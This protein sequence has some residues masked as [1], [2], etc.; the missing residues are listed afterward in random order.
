MEKNTPFNIFVLAVFIGLIAPLAIQD[1]M[2]MDGQIYAAVSHNLANGYG[3]FWFPTFSKYFMAEYSEQLPLFFWI[4]GAF[5]KVLGSSIYTE[6]IFSFIMAMITA[7]NISLIW[8]L[9]YHDQ[10]QLKV[11]T[12]LPIFYWIMIPVIS[13]SYIHN[14]EE[15]LMSVFATASVYFTL[16]GFITNKNL[17]LNILISGILIFLTSFCK[18]VQGLFPIVTIAFYWLFYKNI[19]FK[20]ALGYSLLLSLVPVI[21]YGFLLWND[22]SYQSIENYFNNRI[23]RTFTKSYSATTDNHFS[24]LKQIFEQLIPVFILLLL[25]FAAFRV[26]LKK[27]L[28]SINWKPFGFFISL[29]LAGSLPLMVTLEQRGFYLTTSLPFT[30]LALAGI[31]AAYLNPVLS[32]L[33]KNSKGLRNFKI[34]SIIGLIGVLVLTG[35]NYGKSKRNEDELH[36]MYAIGNSI[37]ENTDIT[38]PRSLHGNYAL[39]AYFIRH[40]HISLDYDTNNIHTY[41]LSL[42]GSEAVIPT[43]FVPTNLELLEYDFYER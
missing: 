38:I 17:V 27:A 7:W 36:D 40:F 8:K 25:S 41:Y 5:F 42:K 33:D 28:V 30:A 31:G 24:L 4:Q 43:G 20:K 14:V 10:P 13:W 18:G 39:R 6:R 11:L 1:G 23:V 26:K 29:G 16:K 37:P 19:S 12:W 15:V 9:I 3:T 35:Y 2:F 32:L 21:I 34:V 22:T